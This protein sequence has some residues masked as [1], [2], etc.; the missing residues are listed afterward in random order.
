MRNK[1]KKKLPFGDVV[2]ASYQVWGK[3]LAAKMVRWAIKTG[4]IVFSEETPFADASMN[5]RSA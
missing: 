5:G 2:I 3:I 1:Q 4:V